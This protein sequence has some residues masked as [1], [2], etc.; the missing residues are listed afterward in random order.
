VVININS[1]KEKTLDQKQHQLD[2]LDINTGGPKWALER[3]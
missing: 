1:E 3:F 2:Q